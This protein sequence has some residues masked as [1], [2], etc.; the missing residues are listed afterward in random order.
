MKW[1]N[2]LLELCDR[3]IFIRGPVQPEYEIILGEVSEPKERWVDSIFQLRH[4][5]IVCFLLFVL[6]VTRHPA[7]VTRLGFLFIILFIIGLVLS[8]EFLDRHSPRFA[9]HNYRVLKLQIYISL[10][11][12]LYFLGYARDLYLLFFLAYLIFA[13]IYVGLAWHVIGTF[14]S[15]ALVVAIPYYLEAYKLG[16]FRFDL[17][18]VITRIGAI[19]LLAAI[20]GYHWYRQ[21]R[22]HRQ[23]AAH[24]QHMLTSVEELATTTDF[25]RVLCKTFDL[26]RESVRFSTA[27]IVADLDGDG[28]HTPIAHY[29]YPE[30]PNFQFQASTDGEGYTGYV[31]ATQQPLRVPPRLKNQNIPEPK[32]P[33]IGGEEPLQSYIGVPLTLGQRRLGVLM[34]TSSKSHAFQ[35]DDEYMMMRVARWVAVAIANANAHHLLRRETEFLEAIANLSQHGI[36]V[37]DENGKVIR[38]NLA[39]QD[40]LG[41]DL[42]EI[43]GH[44]VSS[45]YVG[46]IGEAKRVKQLM[47]GS[48]GRR[49]DIDSEICTKSGDQ[50]TISLSAVQLRSP[51]GEI[52]GTI[53]YFRDVRQEPLSEKRQK[54]LIEV[55]RLPLR[56]SG[57]S[58][59]ELG[60]HILNAL[61]RSAPAI[62][63]A[64]LHLRDK[65]VLIPSASFGEVPPEYLEMV[66]ARGQGVPGLVWE[67]GQQII[68][69][70]PTMD[71]RLAGYCLASWQG[72]ESMVCLPLDTGELIVGTLSLYSDHVRQFPRLELAFY[73]DFVAQAALSIA[74]AAGVKAL[75]SREKTST[76]R[77]VAHMLAHE[78]RSPVTTIKGWMQ[79]LQEEPDLPQREN[80]LNECVSAAIRLERVID[81]QLVYAQDL[82]LVPKHTALHELVNRTLQIP[83][84]REQLGRRNIDVRV[85]SVP[86]WALVDTNLLQTV[87]V[88]IVQNSIDVLPDGGQIV[89]G[90]TRI[91]SGETCINISDNGP[92]ISPKDFP[93]PQEVFEP[94]RSTKAIIGRSGTGLGLSLAKRIVKAHR[95]EIL[96]SNLEEKP[97][98]VFTIILPP[99]ISFA[100]QE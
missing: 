18:H 63:C 11:G 75:I 20:S 45:L 78:M 98:A 15:A 13:P 50:V 93:D 55:S 74:N 5:L 61:H 65:N 21:I 41:Y 27:L 58:G 28:I 16:E 84:I 90:L 77:N 9:T 14:E 26:L 44:N 66:L 89:I 73:S 1:L 39:A 57:S 43:Q 62:A 86:T 60:P 97:G 54:A 17:E 53:G 80:A 38:C 7:G 83:D 10:G 33:R 19:I 36:I 22:Y 31:L 24:E 96:A 71:S 95:G 92:G 23:A 82:A 81:Q 59:V 2:D 25:D 56:H 67:T 94:F 85:H 72:V 42:A 35:A 69:R 3:L 52:L 32:Y 29:G 51:R 91:A 4:A 99:E 40:M 70:K 37:A 46:G 12:V 47:S 64:I 76:I 6:V 68:S 49:N 48:G 88:N 79:L 30:M 100:A 34:V 87:L 8:F